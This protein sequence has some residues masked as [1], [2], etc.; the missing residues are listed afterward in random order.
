M[1]LSS[2]CGP[3]AIVYSSLMEPIVEGLLLQ[4]IKARMGRSDQRINIT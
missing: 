3:A 4:K 2:I 1:R